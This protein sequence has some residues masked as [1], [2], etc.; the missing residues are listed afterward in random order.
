VALITRTRIAAIRFLN[1]APL[2]W[3][4]THPPLAESL[5]TRYQLDWMLPSA[6]ADSLADGTTDLGL[7]P[8]AAL[9]TNPTLQPLPGSTIASK[10]HVRSLILVHR[11]AQ[12]IKSLRT[13][14]ADTASRTTL[15]Y[16]RIL[17]RLR[18]N[19]EAIFLPQ[20][21]DLDRMLEVADAAL[22]IGD[23]ALLALEERANRLERTG[24][25]LIYHDLAELWREQTGLAWVSAIWAA[26]PLFHVTSQLQA[27]LDHSRIHGLKNIDALV[28]EWSSKL[29]IAEAT[30]RTYLTKNI[31]YTLDAE[32]L[33]AIHGFFRLASETG[34]LP[35]YKFNLPQF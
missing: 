26:A 8:I 16:T 18:G 28:C 19:N 13:I 20:I 9:A 5:A 11:A 24:E 30:I 6:C 33:E 35:Q 22:L 17:F 12:T 27:D 2:M 31:H 34:V 3:D 4:F 10:Q 14:A 21:A 25:E 32:C 23:A 7:V 15:A 29:P 1:P